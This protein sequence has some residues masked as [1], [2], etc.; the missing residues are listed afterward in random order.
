[1]F[2]SLEN[3]TTPIAISAIQSIDRTTSISAKWICPN[4]W[5]DQKFMNN[6]WIFVSFFLT[7][8]CLCPRAFTKH[9]GRNF[10]TLFSKVWNT[11]SYLN[12]GIFL[13]FFFLPWFL[14]FRILKQ[15]PIIFGRN[16]N[17]Y[18][19]VTCSFHFS[20]PTRNSP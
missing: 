4:H 16:V 20:P 13:A 7:R 1:M 15:S 5:Q 10:W 19:I 14:F 18:V 9:Y 3:S 6:S 8:W 11:R 17:I 2:P 12:I